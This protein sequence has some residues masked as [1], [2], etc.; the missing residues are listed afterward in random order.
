[1][2]LRPVGSNQTEL[3]IN[4]I[5]ILFS[6]T[7]PVAILGLGGNYKTEK[8]YSQT[9]TRHINSFFK[10]L[11]KPK[12]ISQNVIDNYFT[13]VEEGANKFLGFETE[14]FLTNVEFI[15]KIRRYKKLN[16]I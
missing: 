12:E 11:E 2:K 14:T 3:T 8:W 7:T 16:W 10:G 1:M 4:G 15:K 5:T 13:M 9:T 6:Y